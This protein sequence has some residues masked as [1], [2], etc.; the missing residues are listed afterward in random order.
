MTDTIYSKAPLPFVGQKKNFLREFRAVL[1]DHIPDE[2]E[3]WTIVDVFGGSGL[4]AH[5][6]KRLLPRARVIF[7]DYDGYADRIANIPDT[8]ALRAEFARLTKGH[9]KHTRLPKDTEAA[10]RKTVENW[11]GFLD[12]LCVCSWLFAHN[13]DSRLD[14]A[15]LLRITWTYVGVRLTDYDA[16]GYLDGLEII[17]ADFREVMRE[18]SGKDKTLLVLDPHYLRTNQGSYAAEKYFGMVDSMTVVE[19]LKPPFILFGSTRSE[20]TEYLDWLK[21]YE[22]HKFQKVEGFRLIAKPM[23]G[24]VGSSY[25]DN[26][27]YKF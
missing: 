24:G 4:L 17:R 21:E 25:E 26:L 19:L 2:G 1:V 23:H 3:G 14:K 6:A 12:L 8:N 5:N 16:T 9:P 7:N 20:I 11:Q 22:P 15:E 13:R 18:H 27:I 10:L